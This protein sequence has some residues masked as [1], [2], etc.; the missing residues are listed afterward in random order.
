MNMLVN[1]DQLPGIVILEEKGRITKYEYQGDIYYYKR[2]R[3]VDNY[4]YE[5]LANIIGRELGIH[6]VS[7]QFAT[8]QDGI[9]TV[10][11]D[12]RMHGYQ[13][14]DDLIQNVYE[15]DVN[16]YNNLE[17]LKMAFER[18][19]SKES[20]DRLFSSLIDAFL[21]DVLIGNS[22][23]HTE[24]YGIYTTPEI[25]FAPLFDHENMLDE[26]AIYGGEYCLGVKRGDYYRRDENL[27]YKMLEKDEKYKN[28]ILTML[29]A[30]SEEKLQMYF[31]EIAEET[32]VNETIKQK[33]LKRFSDNEIM[34][35]RGL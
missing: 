6:T 22:D 31:S 27:F 21:F 24:N 33:I 29:P 3:S 7:Y 1:L 2:S 13:N 14:I 18:L 20:A 16:Q 28:K 15:G 17:D 5:V 10:S 9:G 26:R 19:F 25:R 30:I 34:I 4:Y 11:K 8:Y 32:F 35:R 23:R 12:Y